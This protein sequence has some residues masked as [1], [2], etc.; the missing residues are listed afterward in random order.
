[1]IADQLLKVKSLV[2][3]VSIKLSKSEPL[4]LA[5]SKTKPFSDIQSAYDA[6]QRH[7]GE[8]YVCI[9]QFNKIC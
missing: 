5:V 4:L 7:F 1:M 3:A 2:S 6:G 8:N 9:R